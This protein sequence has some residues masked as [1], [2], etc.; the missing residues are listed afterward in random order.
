[1]VDL[2]DGGQI[3]QKNID[4]VKSRFYI[5]G[6]EPDKWREIPMSR[7][8]RF[9]WLSVVLA[10]LLVPMIS[11]RLLASEVQSGRNDLLGVKSN[12]KNLSLLDPQ[13]LKLYQSYTFSYFSDSRSSGSL[14]VYT[15]TLDYRL[16]EPLSLTLSLN[17]LHQPLSV[18]KRTNSGTKGDIL[19][20]FQ[21]RYRPS[22]SFSLLIDVVT[23][24]STYGWGY[25]D[26]WWERHR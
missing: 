14:G 7:I 15:T 8:N 19:P 2:S 24:P 6:D 18:F 20:N 5:L 4:N 3:L 9:L 11:I 26:L 16:S 25:E 13:R 17:Y 1:M 21:L 23:L 10:L 12:A 22:S